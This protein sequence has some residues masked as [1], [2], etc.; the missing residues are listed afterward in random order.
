MS[1]IWEVRET[2]KRFEQDFTLLVSVKVL[3]G[4]VESILR[5]VMCCKGQSKQP[6]QSKGSFVYTAYDFNNRRGKKKK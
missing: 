1:C 3:K 4:L 5:L 6:Y 2:E